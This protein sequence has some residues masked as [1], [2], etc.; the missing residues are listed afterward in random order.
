MKML[1][2]FVLIFLLC[3]CGCLIRPTEHITTSG[4][5]TEKIITTN[6]EYIELN[7]NT[8]YAVNISTYAKVDIGKSY[9]ITYYECGNTKYVISLKQLN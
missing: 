1:Y 2:I 8:V 3:T 6:Y 4:I 7:N 5:A 9:E